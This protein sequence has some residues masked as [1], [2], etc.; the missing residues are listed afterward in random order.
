M[1][2]LRIDPRVL[3]ERCLSSVD[4]YFDSGIG[5]VVHGQDGR[6]IYIDNGSN[7]LAVAHLDTVRQD[8]HYLTDTDFIMVAQLDDRL[9]VHV[10]LDVLPA[11]GVVVDVLLTENEEWG[12]S[13]AK[14]FTPSKDY[15]WMFQFDRSGTDVVMYDYHTQSAETILRS[16]GFDVG[17]GSYSDICELTHVGV[18]GFNFGTAYYQ[19]HSQTAFLIPSQLHSMLEKFYRFWRDNANVKMEYVKPVHVPKVYLYGAT[20][21]SNIPSDLAHWQDVYAEQGWI[22]SDD[23]ERFIYCGTSA[24]THVRPD[25]RDL[26]DSALCYTFGGKNYYYTDIEYHNR[27]VCHCGNK[28]CFGYVECPACGTYYDSHDY[29]EQVKYMIR[30]GVCMYCLPPEVT[31]NE[32]E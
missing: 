18:L 16:Y 27:E 10:I 17:Y 25:D 2:R 19:N 30:H 9:G 7:V 21:S 14:W 3:K 4:D 26:L 29:P 24:V 13:S 8:R 15:N 23:E 1:T 6:Y 5:E 28:D 32:T 11:A 22:W 31:D 12:M 20:Q